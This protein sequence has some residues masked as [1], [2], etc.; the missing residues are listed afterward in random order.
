MKVYEALNT[1]RDLLIPSLKD[2]V[3]AYRVSETLLMHVLK[4]PKERLLIMFRD[5][6]PCRA[7]KSFVKL[8]RRRLA[9]EPLQYLLGYWWFYDRKFIVRKGVLIPRQDTE[10]VIEAIKSIEP[11]LPYP[12]TAVDAGSGSGIIGITLKLEFS[13][14][15]EVTCIDK[16]PKAV[17]LTSENARMHNASICVLKGD[18]FTLA[19]SL[20]KRF[21]L[22]VSNPPYVK[23]N[24]LKRLQAEVKKE[25]VTALDGGKHGIN[26]YSRLARNGGN[27]LVPGGY[28]VLEIGDKMGNI[29]KKT[30]KNRLGWKFI[31]AYKDFRGCTRALIFRFLQGDPYSISG[32][33]KKIRS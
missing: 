18:F 31:R 21:N 8:V 4:I 13:R 25:P 14:F 24:A 15:S 28:L 30:F 32:K 6:L 27:F 19:A 22:V 17:K 2:R 3:F 26:F 11:T 16:N 33:A 23:K 9:G 10:A 12:S 5:E 20:G 1:G 29:V 7:E